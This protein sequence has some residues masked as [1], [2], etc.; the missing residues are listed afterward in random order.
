LAK[1]SAAD[2]VTVLCE[3]RCSS[4][5]PRFI[6]VVVGTRLPLWRLIAI[7]LEGCKNKRVRG[8]AKGKAIT[9][10]GVIPKGYLEK[11]NNNKIDPARS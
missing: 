8:K 5:I 7:C 3:D 11:S 1:L 2:T 10:L 9:S 4:Q 6:A